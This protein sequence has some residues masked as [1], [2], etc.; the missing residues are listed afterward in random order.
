MRVTCCFFHVYSLEFIPWLC[1]SI[2]PE[3]YVHMK[4][5]IAAEA[6]QIPVGDQ[7]TQPALQLLKILG[8]VFAI[9]R[10][11]LRKIIS[12]ICAH[13]IILSSVLVF[14]AER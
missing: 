10:S 9:Q 6:T 8:Q 2:L 3:D 1:S 4:E 11:F 14:A 5:I 7:I 13:K 12:G